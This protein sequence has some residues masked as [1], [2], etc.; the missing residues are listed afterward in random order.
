MSW[1]AKPPTIR[2]VPNYLIEVPLADA[3]EREL[4]RALRMLEAAYT[5]TRGTATATRTVIA[6]VSR[7]DGRLVCLIEAPNIEAARRAVSVA[8]LPPGRI[9]EITHLV[10][11]HLLG[12]RDPGG[13]G[14]PRIEPELVEDVVDMGLDGALGEE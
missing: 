6:G 11:T 10:G 2:T 4:G 7:A 12:G 14:D 1:A 3:G 9:R 5:R 13:D 8:L